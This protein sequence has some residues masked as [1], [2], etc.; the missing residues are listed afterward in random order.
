MFDFSRPETIRVAL[1]AGG[2]SGEREISLASK[3]GALEALLEAGYDVE[4]FDPANRDDL[5]ALIENDFD[6]AFLALHGKGGEDGTVQGFLELIG[7]PYTGSGVCASAICI[8]KKKA[9][10]IYQNSGIPTPPSV[11]IRH[12]DTYN[13]AEII[14]ELG[15]KCVVKAATE[16]SSLGV[17]IVEGTKE[18]EDAIEEALSIDESVIVEKYIPGREF[19][20]VVLGDGSD[21]HA[22]P[23]IE[24]IPQGTSY[25]FESKYRPGGSEHICPAEIPND[26]TGKIQTIAEKAHRSLDCKGVSRTDFLLEENGDIWVLETNTLPGMTATSLLPDAAR[27]AGIEFPEL[28]TLLIKSALEN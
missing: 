10:I 16:G 5:K 9:K 1:L 22:L 6:V 4:S 19:T 3:E 24:I 20:V 8:D 15:Q 21:A 28:C 25:D 14:K 27:A 11:E 12:G 13:T 23:I 17:F 2:T 18:L 7:L 26:I